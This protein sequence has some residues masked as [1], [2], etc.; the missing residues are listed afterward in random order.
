MVFS[1][2][3]DEIPAVSLVVRRR[4]L[5]VHGLTPRALPLPRSMETPSGILDLIVDGVRTLVN[6]VELVLYVVEI[7]CLVTV[8]RECPYHYP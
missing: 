2:V 1:S 6:L 3:M 4:S 5:S 8:F 7:Y